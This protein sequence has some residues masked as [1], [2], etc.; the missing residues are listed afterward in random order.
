[1]HQGTTKEADLDFGALTQSIV[2]QIG[3]YLPTVIGALAILLLGWIVAVVL[4]AATRR[5]LGAVGLNRRLHSGTETSVDLE[6]LVARGV[7]YVVIL[8]A[9][10]AFLNALDL[11]LVSQPLQELVST[12][13]A[14]LPNLVGAAV[15]ALVAWLVATVL[16]TVT[17]HALRSGHLDEKITAAAD[18]R[19]VSESLGQ[20]VYGLVLLLFLP[21]ILGALRLDGLLTPVQNLV[22]EILNYLPNIIAAAAIAIIGWFVAGLI[23]DIIS[24]LLG[25]AGADR[26]GERIGLRG[27]L[28]LSRLM[29]LVVFVLVL[30]PAVV[31]ALEALA[32]D[33]IS[34]PASRMLEAF[35]GTLPNVFAAALILGLS[36]LVARLLGTLTTSLLAGVGAD[37]LPERL[38]LGGTVSD[39]VK[40][41]DLAGKFVV[42]FLLL[43]ATVEAADVLGFGQISDLVAS[44]TE[45]GGQVLL[46]LAV[47]GVGLWLAGIAHAAV[48]SVATKNG[49]F[50]AG[51]VRVAILGVIVAMGLRAMGIAD[52]IVNLAFGLTLGA[53]AVSFALAFGLGGREAAGKQ[54]DHWLSGLR[55]DR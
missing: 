48:L 16:R 27:D 22:G 36:Y 14:F 30:V 54:L 24:S 11:S 31:A 9:F 43:F 23:R 37:A 19:P 17:V 29:G 26:L 55:G 40:I 45:F 20:A 5:L 53:V 39:R 15:L 34:A 32:I 7:F 35:L 18:M 4:R 51:L 12:F 1:M 47:I 49:P 8:L 42:F 38:G 2:S 33:T 10:V 25:A 6:G 46:G 50:L 52:D 13:L 44:F 3:Q 21:A 41:S 28:T